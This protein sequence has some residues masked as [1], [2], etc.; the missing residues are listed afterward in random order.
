MTTD[1][2]VGEF[3]G[4]AVRDVAVFLL[5]A[6]L[7][8]RLVIK[9]KQVVRDGVDRVARLLKVHTDRTN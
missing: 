4:D 8:R 5:L 2:V 3:V 1:Q 9:V 7:R 6:A